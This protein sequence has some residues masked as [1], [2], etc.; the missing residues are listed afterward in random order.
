MS[1]RWYSKILL[2]IK[3]LITYQ[4]LN[5]FYIERCS[6]I[7]WEYEMQCFILD[8]KINTAFENWTGQQPTIITRFLYFKS[9]IWQKIPWTC[10]LPFFFIPAFINLAEV[11]SHIHS[12]VPWFIKSCYATLHILQLN[13]H[14]AAG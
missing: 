10:P 4:I 2:S 12:T 14:L 1:L 3:Y 7:M 8:L 9:H 13:L 11:F 6:F 5:T